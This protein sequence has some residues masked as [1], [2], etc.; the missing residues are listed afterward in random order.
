MQAATEAPV[1]IE[2]GMRAGK[3]WTR[4]AATESVT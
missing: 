3:T 2:V 1:V 4:K